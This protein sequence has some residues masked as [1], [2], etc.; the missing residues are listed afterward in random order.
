MGPELFRTDADSFSAAF[1]A[2]R[3]IF[4]AAADPVYRYREPF[5]SM[6]EFARTIFR[7]FCYSRPSR[8]RLNRDPE[9]LEWVASDVC[10]LIE[11]LDLEDRARQELLAMALDGAPQAHNGAF[12]EL[13]QLINPF[14]GIV[15]ERKRR[16]GEYARD[17]AAAGRPA[18]LH[19]LVGVLYRLLAELDS[20]GMESLP[21]VHM[22]EEGATLLM[23]RM[24]GNQGMLRQWMRVGKILTPLAREAYSPEEREQIMPLGEL[25]K[26][27]FFDV[28][29]YTYD[30]DP[31]E[32]C[33]Q[34][35]QTVEEG[36]TL[37]RCARCRVAVYCGPDCQRAAWNDGHRDACVAIGR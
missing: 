9:F 19:R 34:C 14:V 5:P 4:R 15:V 11:A 22:P 36:H 13:S 26:V 1:P 30:I 29:G 18:H 28:S 6:L 21:V 31:L 3:R 32:S 37:R 12:S 33:D 25:A 17:A 2:I 8:K 20:K 16:W 24:L 23:P 27:V 10:A 35:R 7:I